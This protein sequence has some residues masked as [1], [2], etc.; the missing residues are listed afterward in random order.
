MKDYSKEQLEI[1]LKNTR[2]AYW[3]VLRSIYRDA[4]N[5]YIDARDAY[6]NAEIE[7]SSAYESVEKAKE[8]M[9]DIS[10]ASDSAYGLAEDLEEMVEKQDTLLI[11]EYGENWKENK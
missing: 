9:E 11:D 10:S 5:L 1:Q 7:L 4:N 6:E 2:V 8:Y 3:R